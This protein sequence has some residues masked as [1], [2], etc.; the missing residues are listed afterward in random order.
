MGKPGRQVV[1]HDPIGQT[2]DTVKLQRP[3]PGR[4][5]TLTLDTAI[6]AHVEAVLA[7]TVKSSGAKWATG[8]VLDPRT[9][10][11]LAMAT[12]PGYDNN[13][14]H[15]L[16][17]FSPTGPTQNNAL[18]TTYEPGS[19]YKV[20]T[21][22]AALSAGLIYPH[23]V[24]RNLPWKI[25]VG[26]KFIHDDVWRRPVS[27]DATQIL[28]KSSNVG[29]DTI[30]QIVGKPLLMHWI[31]AYGFGRRTGVGMPNVESPGIVLP[32]RS[33]TASSIGTIPIGQ[34]IG[35]TAMQ[36]AS[37][38]QTIANG[39][40]MVPPRLVQALGGRQIPPKRRAP[41]PDPG[42][43]P[44]AGRHARHGR[45]GRWHGL[46]CLDL[47]L[48]GGRQDRHGAEA[49]E[50]RRLLDD[51]LRRVVRRASSRRR[52]RRS[53]SWSWSTLRA[54]ATSAESSRRPR[55]SRSEPGWPTI[56][57]S[58]RTG[59]AT[60]AFT[61]VRARM[62]LGALIEAV[63]PRAVRGRTE[64][65][66]TGVTYRADAV[67]PGALHVC[68][69]GHT[70]DGHDFAPEAV[71]RGAAALVV[72]RDLPL[73]VTQLVVE[74]SRRAM[75]AAADAF[76]GRPSAA[77][78]VV[79]ITGT[80]GKTT[81]AF[82]VHA[83]L[84]AAGRQ[85]GLL[86]TVEQ[87]VG[88]R[89]EPV[90]R[91]T[92]ESVDLQALLRRM[93]DAGDTACVMEVSSH[94]LELERVA[95]VRFAAAAFTNLT[96]DHLD[97]HPDMEHYYR[98]KA[99]LFE[100][101]PAA[102]NV[103]DPYGRRLAG[104]AGGPVLTYGRADPAADVRAHA[105]EIG[106]GG[107]ISLIA[108]TPRGPLPLDVR[109]RGGFN[110]E[111]VLCAVALGEVLE[112]PHDAVRAGLAAVAGVP[113][114]FEPVDAGQPFTVLVDYAHTPDGLENL[115]RS[116]REI[117]AGRLICVFGCGG[118]RDRG[119]RPLM[120]AVVRRLADVAV[121]T[122]DNPRSEDPAAIIADITA[123]F[124]MDVEIDRRAAI[125]AGSRDRRAGRRRRHRRQGARAGAGAGR[126]DDPVR[127]PRGGARGALG[128]RGRGVIPLSTREIAAVAGGTDVRPRRD[129]DGRRD[130]LPRR[131][132]GRP[133]RRPA[134]RAD[135]RGEVRRHRAGGRRRRRPPRA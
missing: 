95:G 87:R 35:V 127:R 41:R 114:R 82:L 118:D 90:V 40:V 15:T 36:M 3:V 99:R 55:S 43:R 5:V 37:M 117:T 73:D 107:V 59:P 42:G 113:G 89:V 39:G 128:A 14:V 70:A 108:A 23:M 49:V 27:Y 30:A 104:E 86:G 83:V 102:I 9:G 66:I 101:A 67:V 34:G 69:P 120:G 115:L 28:Q 62:Q 20:V 52:I 21:F 60:A 92:P 126:P 50:V 17:D 64:A 65:E 51:R 47:R 106:A 96:Q 72:E 53:R 132:A 25:R 112:L 91:T 131:R 110:V 11:I 12:S 33:W 58:A 97:F 24:F 133:L 109:L 61:R 125:R 71:R 81:T 124:A 26:D 32:G 79:G 6:Q 122:S 116:A 111:N 119:K 76:F 134:R 103:D 98:A 16:S 100:A 45:A 105:V 38:Y 78:D 135:A 44:R 2:L 74:S 18:V 56:S 130:R 54:R 84:E 121:V 46:Q 80:N 75:A 19:T 129:R 57:A 1:V 29:T 123:G 94:A 4:D 85:S 68:V 31:R 7:Q 63:R 10:S 77:L 93:V 48:L 8:I 88:G 13:K 22:S